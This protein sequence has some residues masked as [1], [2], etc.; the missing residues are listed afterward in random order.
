MPSTVGGGPAW[1]LRSSAPFVPIPPCVEFKCDPDKMVALA[2]TAAGAT[3][4]GLPKATGANNPHD[5]GGIGVQLVTPATCCYW[6]KNGTIAPCHIKVCA[7]LTIASILGIRPLKAEENSAFSI[8]PS[9][10][11]PCGASA[12]PENL[13]NKKAA[14]GLLSGAQQLS[15]RQSGN[16]HGGGEV[17]VHF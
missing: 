5:A 7:Q 4:A 13:R 9:T 1:C 3:A 15:C 6:D 8:T 2:S 14:T 10:A 12:K 16:P 11:Y 17:Q